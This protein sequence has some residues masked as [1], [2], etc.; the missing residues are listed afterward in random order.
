MYCFC[1][2]VLLFLTPFE[3]ELSAFETFYLATVKLIAEN[4]AKEFT[5]EMSSA[6]LVPATCSVNMH[7]IAISTLRRT[8]C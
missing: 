6:V 8:L 3:V 5:G 2:S 1:L 7:S 4:A